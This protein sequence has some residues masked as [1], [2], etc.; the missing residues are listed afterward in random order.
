MSKWIRNYR[1]T[2]IKKGEDPIVV[3]YPITIEFSVRREN[4]SQGGEGNFLIMNLGKETR[5]KMQKHFNDPP[6]DAVVKLEAGYGNNLSV[7]FNGTVRWANS[8]RPE[9]SVNFVTQINGFDYGTVPNNSNDQFTVTGKDASQA[10]VIRRLCGCLKIVDENL[11]Y[12]PIPIGAIGT[13]DETEQTK[14]SLCGSAWEELKKVSGRRC[15]ID[16]GRVYVLNDNDVLE[17]AEIVVSSDSGLLGTPKID[18]N[19]LIIETIFEPAVRVGGT[20]KIKSQALEDQNGTYKII[21]IQH[22]GTISGAVSGKC[23][24]KIVMM[25]GRQGVDNP[26]AYIKETR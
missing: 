8:H 26:F 12:V 7:I 14:Y 3:Q 1:L 6:G 20:I 21:S 5:Q 19:Q 25:V 24:T 4:L 2:W 23:K 17:G 9:G 13:F 11:N 10:S 15:Y 18:Q 16:N 22:S